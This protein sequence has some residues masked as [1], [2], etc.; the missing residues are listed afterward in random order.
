MD[1]KYFSVFVLLVF[2][3]LLF[4]V[5]YFLLVPVEYEDA[6]IRYCQKEGFDTG[7]CKEVSLK[8]EEIITQEFLENATFTK[9]PCLLN[10]IALEMETTLRCFCKNQT[11]T[12]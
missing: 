12:N 9:G 7:F 2:L 11:S 10:P 5:G 1:S 8:Q 4:V 3:A 6:C